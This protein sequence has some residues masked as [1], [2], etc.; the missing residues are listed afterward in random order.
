MNFRTEIKIPASDFKITH[1]DELMMMGS[2]FVENISR[3]LVSSGFDVDLNPFGIAYN[4]ASVAKNIDILLQ[5]KKYTIR[6][7]FESQGVFHSFDHHSQFSDASSE[8]CLNRINERVSRS[9]RKL[10]QQSL[11]VVTFGTAFVYSLKE[12]GQIVS[13]CH[14]LPE[15]AFERTRLSVNEIVSEWSSLV[16]KLRTFNPELKILF[17]VSPVRH[18][19]DGA[20]ENQLSKSTL[21][22]SIDALMKDY[23][24]IYYFP[25][26]EILMDELRDYR[27]YAD[28]MLHPSNQAI[29]YIWEKFSLTFFDKKTVQLANERMRI[30]KS[31]EHK[32][33]H[34]DSERYQEFLKNIQHKLDDFDKN[35]R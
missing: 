5:C 33:F 22:L 7:L 8:R 12:T 18:W 13:N 19:K 10:K 27:F 14:K 6:D 26:Y 32:P 3:M 35:C 21:L 24:F 1:R 9:S 15:K 30:Q 20:H 16:L 29:E 4:P 25:S 31:L 34:P 2:C 23:P 28:D 11:L 17:T